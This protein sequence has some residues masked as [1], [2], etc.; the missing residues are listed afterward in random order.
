MTLNAF[1]YIEFLLPLQIQ[2]QFYKRC[3]LLIAFLFSLLFCYK[4][5]TVP[6]GHRVYHTVILVKSYSILLFI[7]EARRTQ[8]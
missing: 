3:A 8:S 5:G 2:L 4:S 7:C 6:L 1:S